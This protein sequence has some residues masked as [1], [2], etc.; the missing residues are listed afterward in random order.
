MDESLVA[1]RADRQSQTLG[2]DFDVMIPDYSSRLY[3]VDSNWPI[4]WFCHAEVNKQGYDG[5]INIVRSL[6]H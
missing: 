5:C 4:R 6:R 2:V 3:A 1:R